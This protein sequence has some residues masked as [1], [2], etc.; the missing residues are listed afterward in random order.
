MWLSRL[1]IQC[2]C[3][4]GTGSTPGLGTSTCCECSQ[5]KQQ[6]QGDM[7]LTSAKTSPAAPRAAQLWA[8][9]PTPGSAAP[10]CTPTCLGPPGPPAPCQKSPCSI[11]AR[12]RPGSP[13]LPGPK[14][15]ERTIRAPAPSQPWSCLGLHGGLRLDPSG[16][17]HCSRDRGDGIP[18]ESVTAGGQA[19][20]TQGS[21]GAEW[22]GVTYPGLCRM[23]DKGHDAG[24]RLGDHGDGFA[25]DSLLL[26]PVD[27]LPPLLLPRLLC[28]LGRGLLLQG[29]PPPA[30]RPLAQGLR[31]ARGAQ[32]PPGLR[33]GW[34]QP[35][36]TPKGTPAG[37]QPG[38]LGARGRQQGTSVPAQGAGPLQEGGTL[39]PPAGRAPW[40]SG[41][42][43]P[44]LASS[45][46]PLRTGGLPGRGAPGPLQEGAESF[47][48]TP[49]PLQ[50][51][52]QSWGRPRPLRTGGLPG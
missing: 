48:G 9:E 24:G 43:L 44:V 5:K 50:G 30:H 4:Y 47:R 11:P 35:R 36:L 23:R 1:R 27:V 6:Q 49:G 7:S 29:L 28:A 14:V 38:K 3:S 19:S 16:P 52:V 8:R 15:E 26:L 2:G 10:P 21:W 39:G 33:A 25:Q 34:R 46:S 13:G 32:G 22:A 12:V 20:R 17:L 40:P 42:A 31:A 37:P 51:G 45:P 18:A 41:R